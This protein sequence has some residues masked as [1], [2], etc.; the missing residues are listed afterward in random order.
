MNATP[1][2]ASYPSIPHLSKTPSNSLQTHHFVNAIS[3][4]VHTRLGSNNRVW[5]AIRPWCGAYSWAKRDGDSASIWESTL[6]PKNTNVRQ[7]D[8][9]SMIV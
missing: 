3:V 9:A 6:G 7:N 2:Y 1:F 8:I 4:V 5:S